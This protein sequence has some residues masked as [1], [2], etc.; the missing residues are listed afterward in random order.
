MI[1]KALSIKFYYSVEKQTPAFC[2]TTQSCIIYNGTNLNDQFVKCKTNTNH[3]IQISTP[4]LLRCLLLS[5]KSSSST[6][7]K[8]KILMCPHH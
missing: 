2:V 8:T 1:Y 6:S 3:D 5:H 7:Q 4:I